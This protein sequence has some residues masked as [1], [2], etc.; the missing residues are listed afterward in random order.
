MTEMYY[1]DFD[2]V[3]D[4]NSLGQALKEFYQDFK[5]PLYKE[6]KIPQDAIVF[7]MT[8]VTGKIVLGINSRLFKK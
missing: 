5:Y 3:I 8:D 6:K 7:N 4:Y 2:G 1:A